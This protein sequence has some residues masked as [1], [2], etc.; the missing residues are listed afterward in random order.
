MLTCS[1]DFELEE[2]GQWQ[3]YC[4]TDFSVF[5][6]KRR[7]RCCSCKALIDI[8]APCLRFDR[9]RLP[10][11]EIEEKIEGDLIEMAP[12]WMCEQCGEIYLN[13]SDIGYCLDITKRMSEYLKDYWEIT[14]YIPAN[15]ALETDGR[16]DGRRSA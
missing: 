8:G 11:T 14:E 6:A 12:L 16:K 2:P 13:L 1:C 5:Q 4:P 3:F 15:K 7:K 9:E 10:C